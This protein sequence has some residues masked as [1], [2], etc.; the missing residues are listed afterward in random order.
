MVIKT[1]RQWR[2]SLCPLGLGAPLSVRVITVTDRKSSPTAGQSITSP[3]VR[4][5]IHQV[6]NH[7]YV[8]TGVT[9]TGAT[10]QCRLLLVG[11]YAFC[12]VEFHKSMPRCTFKN[13]KTVYLL[14]ATMGS[15]MMMN[16]VM[17]NGLKV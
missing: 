7:E 11:F 3:R 9:L 4:T 8:H 5:L 15:W 13:I 17:V 2:L 16:K 10:W 6:N 1:N 14:V 12:W